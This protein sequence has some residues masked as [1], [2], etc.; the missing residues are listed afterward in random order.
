MDPTG[1][2]ELKEIINI[3]TRIIYRT[4]ELEDNV[5]MISN[6]EE[7]KFLLHYGVILSKEYHETSFNDIYIA[8]VYTYYSLNLGEQTTDHLYLSLFEI[9]C[10]NYK[11]VETMIIMITTSNNPI[12]SKIR[13]QFFGMTPLTINI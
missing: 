3:F 7:I 2:S 9:Y 6:D 5:N 1:I 12:G 13:R 4:H 10:D 11:N 8:L